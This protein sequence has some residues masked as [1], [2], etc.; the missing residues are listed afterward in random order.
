MIQLDNALTKQEA[1]R[2]IVMELGFRLVT[3]QQVV[4]QAQ[5]EIGELDRAALIEF[6]ER[7]FGKLIWPR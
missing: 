5:L 1:E 6:I 7:R 2:F 3:A 4:Y